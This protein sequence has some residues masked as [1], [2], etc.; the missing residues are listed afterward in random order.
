MEEERE[1]RAKA[2]TILLG[3]DKTKP[4]DRAM[5]R[6]GRKKERIGGWRRREK[7]QGWN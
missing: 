7:S 5:E 3:I 1:K 2:G 4:R 6:G